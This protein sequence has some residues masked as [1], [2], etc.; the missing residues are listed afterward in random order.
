MPNPLKDAGLSLNKLKA[1][2]RV[3]GIKGLKVCLEMSY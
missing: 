1:V 3:R 2:A